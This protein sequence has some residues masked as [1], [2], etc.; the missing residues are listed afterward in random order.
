MPPVWEGHAEAPEGTPAD[1]AVEVP[2]GATRAASAR[3]ALQ[4]VT[5]LTSREHSYVHKMA[6]KSLLME[7]SVDSGSED[8]G[9]E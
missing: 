9:G 3:S 5:F 1:A 2:R 4:A 7:Q 8:T 6:E